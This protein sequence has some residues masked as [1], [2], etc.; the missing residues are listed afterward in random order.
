MKYI[1]LEIQSGDTV[2]TIVDQYD[3]RQAAESKFHQ[4][5]ASAAISSVP[6]HSAILMSDDGFPLRNESYKHIAEPEPEEPEE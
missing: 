2:A 4:I 6:I 3:T 5:L 1:V